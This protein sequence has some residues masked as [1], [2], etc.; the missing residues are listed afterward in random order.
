M[1]K[2]KDIRFFLIPEEYTIFGTEIKISE[3]VF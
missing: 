3:F 1:K 2:K